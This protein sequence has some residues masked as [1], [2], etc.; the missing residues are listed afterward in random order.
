VIIIAFP[1]IVTSHVSKAAGEI[2]GSGAD[3]IR[4]QL[5]LPGT[6]D[7]AAPGAAEAG[8]KEGEEDPAAAIDRMLK[9]QK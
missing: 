8:K 1:G 4:R 2:S 3:E 9:Q 7:T 5:Q 6:P